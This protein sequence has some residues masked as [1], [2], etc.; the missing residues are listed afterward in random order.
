LSPLFFR[1][2]GQQMSKY[3]E[4]FK[5]P[6]RDEAQYKN[7]QAQS[8]ANRA[9][10]A[11]RLLFVDD[12]ENVLKALTRIF[13]E[14]NYQIL[15]AL[16]GQAALEIIE[17]NQ[18]HLVISDFKM[19]GMNGSELLAEI[20]SRQPETIRIML[21]GHA[22]I[23]AITGAI[24]E[25][26][27]YKFITKPWNDEDLRITVSLALQQY[28]LVKENKK[29]KELAK[30]QQTKIGTYSK[31]FDEYRGVLGNIL[32]ATGAITTD[33]LNRATK[34]RQSGESMGEAVVRLGFTTEVK[35]VQAVQKHQRVEGIDLKETL[36]NPNVARLFPYEF[37]EKNRCISVRIDGKNLTLAMADPTDIVKIDNISMMTGFQIKPVIAKS[38]DIKGLID[39]TYGVVHKEDGLR[40]MAETIDYE[41]MEEIDVVIDEEE[42][43]KSDLQELVNS[44]EIP[45]IIR[46]VNAII[47]EALRFQASDIHIEPKTKHTIVRFRIDGMLHTKLKIPSSLHPAT[48]SR[49]KILSKMDISERRKPQDGRITIKTGTRIVDVRVATMPTISGE[50]VVLRILDKNAS[51]K[52]LAQLGISD[53]DLHRMRLIINK[54]QG[55]LISTGPTGSGKTTMLYSIL[56]EMLKSTKNFE[57]IEDPVEYF[58]EDAN[59]VYVREHIGLSFASVLRATLRQDPDVLLVGEIRDYE[60]ADV[61]FKA[62]LTGHMVLSTLHTN[63]TVASITRL[64]DLGV[65]PYLIASAIEGIIAQRLV[66]KV[67]PHCKTTEAPEKDTMQLLKVSEGVITEEARGKG[68]NRCNNTGYHGRTGIF[69]VFVLNDEIRQLVS[70]NYRESE[71]VD[72]AKSNG[73]R[74]LMEDGIEKVKSGVTTLEELLRVIGPPT[75]HERTCEHCRRKV[76]LKF[77]FCP[78]CGTFRQ[79]IC[80]ECRIPLEEDWIA[81]P[82]CGTRKQDA[83]TR[84]A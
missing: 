2:R 51:I 45:P 44:S 25:G 48:I 75:K 81:C 37:C 20:K 50:K 22:D 84:N 70:S 6:P 67:C 60:T 10:E 69:E 30:T 78:F 54:P 35:L 71:I 77:V 26:A 4:L 28:E 40:D 46:I 43:E 11:F 32:T 14:E 36:V 49:I 61:A 74:T 23:Q 68:C 39:K 55:I 73:M 53:N 12:E 24:N 58:L 29:L 47:L 38:S 16:S 82:S 15:T 34:E 27:V 62:A 65:K 57:T 42:E 19:P 63:H 79:N 41:P 9:S 80:T 17:S 1:S 76:D 5:S 8:S 66:R 64:I 59:Q 52:K 13:L 72:L 56:H 3:A 83:V 7:F 31:L 18:V 21:T 33:Q